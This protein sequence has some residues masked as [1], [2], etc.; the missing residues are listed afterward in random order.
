[1][2]NNRYDRFGTANS[3]NN[4]VS[5]ERGVAAAYSWINRTRDWWRR[6]NGDE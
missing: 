3:I 4:G 5:Q 6:R 2:I 1:M